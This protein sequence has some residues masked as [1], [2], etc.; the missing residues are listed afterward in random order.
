MSTAAIMSITT[1][2]QNLT[3]ST[4]NLTCPGIDA[5]DNGLGQDYP[6]T[7]YD[8]IPADMWAFGI[9][10]GNE[11]VTKAMIECCYPG[12][13]QLADLCTMWCEIP[14]SMTSATDADYTDA[15]VERL[16]GSMVRCLKDKDV[17]LPFST[18]RGP[19]KSATPS[20]AGRS[21]LKE[22]GFGAI[23][24]AFGLWSLIVSEVVL[25]H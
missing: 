13:P 12:L 10:A 22:N 2:V 16:L 7:N 25:G 23:V 19:V 8:T 17:R 24:V 6:L 11:T 1:P 14:Q 5:N 3:S 9:R 4:V 21:T 18:V 20:A 15:D